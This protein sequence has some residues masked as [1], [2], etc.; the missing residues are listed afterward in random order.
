MLRHPLA[1]IFFPRSKILEKTVS[2]RERGL[3]C[4]L[5]SEPRC[6]ANQR[7]LKVSR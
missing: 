5:L 4:V 7:V 1:V 2:V 6:D 3:A